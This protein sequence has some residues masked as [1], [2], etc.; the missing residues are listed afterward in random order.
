[1][2]KSALL[3]Q[4]PFQLLY[5]ALS[6]LGLEC[7]F[8]PLQRSVGQLDDHRELSKKIPHAIFITIGYHSNSIWMNGFHT[9]HNC[10]DG[11]SEK[12]QRKRLGICQK[13]PMDLSIPLWKKEIFQMASLIFGLILPHFLK[14]EYCV[15]VSFMNSEEHDVPLHVDDSDISHQYII[16]VGSWVGADLVCLDSGNPKTAKEVTAFN[17]TRQM[18]R[19]EGRNLHYVRK[20]GFRGR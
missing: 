9:P 4:T 15:Y 13:H 17:Q 14:H 10:V 19:I 2:E 5:C 11:T 18:V 20:R 3:S 1:M 6:Q 16:L 8:G 12:F 7:S